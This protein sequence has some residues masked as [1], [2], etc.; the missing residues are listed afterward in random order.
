MVEGGSFADLHFSEI[1][2]RV[3]PRCQV[4]LGATGH[5][6]VETAAL[7]SSVQKERKIQLH[8]HVCFRTVDSQMREA[9]LSAKEQT[10]VCHRGDVLPL[11]GPHPWIS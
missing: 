4:S 7:F 1:I 3:Y 2:G 11:Q 9:D 10:H 6:W 8:M 5:L